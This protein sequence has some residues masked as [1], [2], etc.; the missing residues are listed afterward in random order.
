[1]K[2]TGS[3]PKCSGA[4]I[5]T[6]RSFEEA[7]RTHQDSPGPFSVETYICASCGFLEQYGWQFSDALK[8]W[9]AQGQLE[10][11]KAKWKRHEAGSGAK[12]APTPV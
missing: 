10:N 4:E 1:M 8:H 11:L 9:R 3:C 7:P 5:Y 6:N 12:P 2:L